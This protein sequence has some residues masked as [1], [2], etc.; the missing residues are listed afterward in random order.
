MEKGFQYLTYITTGILTVLLGA[1][2][3]GKHK[4]MFFLFCFSSRKWRVQKILNWPNSRHIFRIYYF[5]LHCWYTLMGGWGYKEWVKGYIRENTRFKLVWFSAECRND[6]IS[7]LYFRSIL[8]L[9][10]ACLNKCVANPLIFN[11]AHIPTCSNAKL[12]GLLAHTSPRCERC[13]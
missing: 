8:P 9:F 7:H 1:A 10:S 2:D 3:T 5:I 13:T 4:M 11:L 12:P 6:R